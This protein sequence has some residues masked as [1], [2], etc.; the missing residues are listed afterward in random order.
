[1]PSLPY[2]HEIVVQ[3]SHLDELNHVNNSV[4]LQFIQEAA[5]QHWYSHVPKTI[6][7]SLRW[8]ARRHEID[9]LK[10]AFLGDRLQIKTWVEA[11]SGVSSD[12][13]CEIY[14]GEELLTKSKTQWVALDFPTL[15]PKRISPE[16]EHYFFD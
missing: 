10:Q 6:T 13:R 12:R 2:L 4:Y 9:Y 15:R 11:F 14:R 16:I 5:M 3:E 8:V 7:D 1:M